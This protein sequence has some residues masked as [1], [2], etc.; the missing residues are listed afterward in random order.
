MKWSNV[1]SF[2]RGLPHLFPYM[3]GGIGAGK[4]LA[5]H[6]PGFKSSGPDW[7]YDSEHPNGFLSSFFDAVNS[8]VPKPDPAPTPKPDAMSLILKNFLKSDYNAPAFGHTREE[9]YNN[10]FVIRA[11]QD[12]LAAMNAPLHRQAKLV[13]QREGANIHNIK[14]MQEDFLRGFKASQDQAAKETETYR[15]RRDESRNDMVGD[16]TDSYA[17]IAN[18]LIDDQR[19][20]GDVAGNAQGLVDKASTEFARDSR[21][22]DSELGAD[23]QF[24][25]ELS[26]SQGM[27]SGMQAREAR[28][29]ADDAVS[30]IHGQIA[31]N[32]KANSVLRNQLASDMFNQWLQ[33]HQMNVSA[34]Q[35]GR[36][37]KSDRMSLIA[38]VMQDSS[39][40]NDLDNILTLLK[41]QKL[42]QGQSPT[43][44]TETDKEDGTQ[45]VISHPPV[46]NKS[47]YDML[48]HMQEQYAMG[49]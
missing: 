34:S 14:G 2:D 35:I 36:A 49:Q 29:K 21:A 13:R 10:P 18:S 3:L 11:A 47:F 1:F 37:D 48:K 32:A 38:K 27:E 43:T 12:A 39:S 24:M 4:V 28:N 20:Q 23:N 31:D 22:A 7:E 6:I 17:R 46:M 5:D 9:A 16:L 26:A 33:E 45:K 25:N 8:Q 30:E 15:K 40:G 41:I 42:Q 19:V 44:I